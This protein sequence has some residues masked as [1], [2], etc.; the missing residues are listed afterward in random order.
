M[1]LRSPIINAV[2]RGSQLYSQG[3]PTPQM[4]RREPQQQTPEPET[5]G[6]VPE[7][8][9]TPQVSQPT[10][11]Q[12]RTSRQGQ[13]QPEIQ[14]YTAEVRPELETVEARLNRL[15]ASDSPYIEQARRE[16]MREA[17]TRGLIN[18]SIAAASGQQAAIREALPIAQADA[19]L[20][21]RERE[22]NQNTINE[23]RRA[24]RESKQGIIGIR[25]CPGDG[26]GRL[27]RAAGHGKR[28]VQFTTGDAAREVQ[29]RAQDPC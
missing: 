19:E 7:A 4:P 28:S 16:T 14:P 21:Q 15:T 5:L 24:K 3:G 26:E 25:Q 2:R 9:E 20:Y 11:E 29:H 10:P 22:L 23:F 27:H 6:A 12:M 18:T 13:Q 8:P 1:P 17:N